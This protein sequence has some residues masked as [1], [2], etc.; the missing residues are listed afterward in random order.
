MV[1]FVSM[2]VLFCFL[3]DGTIYRRTPI[4]GASG[5]TIMLDLERQIH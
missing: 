5:I 1:Q 4:D 3:I 2:R